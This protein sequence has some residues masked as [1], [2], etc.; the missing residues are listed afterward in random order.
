MIYA[1]CCDALIIIARCC[2]YWTIYLHIV[3]SSRSNILLPLAI[4]EK[5]ENI[6]PINKFEGT[7]AIW[8]AQCTMHMAARWDLRK[9]L[10]GQKEVV[11]SIFRY[12]NGPVIAYGAGGLYLG[13]VKI[14]RG[15]PQLPDAFYRIKNIFPSQSYRI[16][17]TWKYS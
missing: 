11:S 16:L 7:N 13:M 5:F 8:R 12:K 9:I 10:Q 17:K 14:N 3:Y 6:N 1:D 4:N 2:N 15:E